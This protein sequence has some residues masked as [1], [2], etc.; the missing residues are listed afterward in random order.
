[1][2]CRNAREGKWGRGEYKSL[3]TAQRTLYTLETVEIM[4]SSAEI[5][6]SDIFHSFLLN[7]KSPPGLHLRKD[8]ILLVNNTKIKAYLSKIC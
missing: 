3:T 2:G 4:T 8:I 5:C 7:R 1:L 6:G